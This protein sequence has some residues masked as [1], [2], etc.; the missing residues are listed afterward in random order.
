MS[1]ADQVRHPRSALSPRFLAALVFGVAAA[2]PA[3]AQWI[4][5]APAPY[6]YNRPG[7]YG[8]ARPLPPFEIRD[9][10]E[11]AGYDPVGPLR[12]D[13]SVYEVEAF[14]PNGRRVRLVVDAFRGVLIGQS[15]VAASRPDVLEWLDERTRPNGERVRRPDPLSREEMPEGGLESD[16][17]SPDRRRARLPEALAPDQDGVRAPLPPV[18]RDRLREEAR[19][20]EPPLR[21]PPLDELRIPDRPDFDIDE[22]DL[23][24]DRGAAR[25][26]ERANTR[27]IAPDDR[28]RQDSVRIDPPA[29]VETRPLDPTPSAPGALPPASSS[30]ARPVPVPSGRLRSRPGRCRPRPGLP[31]R[32]REATRPR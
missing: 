6:G 10:L 21:T 28:S 25:T 14:A 32:P 1:Q 23:P 24:S 5:S 22:D 20:T 4:G 2:S 11:S 8:G 29:P 15:R 3:V 18:S 30:T 19:R 31:E 7:P 9:R 16:R 26:R 12:Y 17:R 27:D 13:G